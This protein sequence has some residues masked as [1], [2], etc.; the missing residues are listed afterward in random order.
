MDNGQRK[1][2]GSTLA[3]FGL[4]L[5]RASYIDLRAFP[6]HHM[7]QFQISGHI[8]INLLCDS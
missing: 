4:D 7:F 2:L 5:T 6:G 8:E 3:R 1:L